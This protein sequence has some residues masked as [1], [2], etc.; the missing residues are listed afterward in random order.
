[1]PRPTK[2]ARLEWRDESFKKDGSL[3]NRAGWFIRDGSTFVS[4][5]FGKGALVDAQKRLAEYVAS[6]HAPERQ[7]GRDPDQVKI[8]DVVAV[9]DE[10]IV[11]ANP[12]PTYQKE[13]AA[14]LLA[15]LD[16][17]GERTLAD[18][19]GQLCRDY[20]ARTERKAAARRQLED[21]RSAVNHY[22]KEGYVTSVPKIVLPEKPGARIRWLSRSEA[23]KLVWAA[24]RMKQSW[25]G[26]MSDRRTG[27]HIARFIL[28]GLYTGTRSG[29][30]CAA[31]IRPTEGRGFVD[32][33]RGVFYRRAADALETKKRQP[34]VRIPDRLLT[35]MR[36]WARTP[37]EIKTKGRGKSRTLGRMISHDY[38]V[39]WEGGPVKSV[40]KGFRSA[41]EAAGLGW[42]DEEGKF[43]TDVTPHVLRHTAATWLMQ[44]GV[45]LSKAA[46]FC[47]M[48]EAVLRKHYYW[49]HPD[50]Q[51]EAAEA[52]TAKAPQ[53]KV[54]SN[55]V[56]L[57]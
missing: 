4:T 32:L 12:S 10:E 39:E 15:I 57:A 20:V 5:G 41:V 29:A 44:N 43:H 50:F 23:A 3:R 42:R 35:H 54:K 55:V 17:F 27:Q 7:K 14:R 11:A 16:F 38:V 6:K 33:D 2:G 34:P 26:Q 9:Y 53:P 51:A 52:I 56:R 48:T 36:R 19:T 30:I 37:V 45:E 49:A 25:K 1:M 13:T 28:T 46:D 40:K 21:L 24:W 8:A 22:H 31:A 18:I 47:G